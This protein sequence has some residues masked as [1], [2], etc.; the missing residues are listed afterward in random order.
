MEDEGGG[1]GGGAGAGGFCAT[2]S[3]A[4][5]GIPSASTTKMRMQW[6]IDRSPRWKDLRFKIL[7]R[8]S[9]P[10]K[11]PDTNNG[12]AGSCDALVSFENSLA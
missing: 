3:G 8:K 5:S 11:V 9:V 4:K 7:G 12:S 2:M 6:P 1:G 10:V